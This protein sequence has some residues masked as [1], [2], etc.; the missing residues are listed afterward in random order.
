MFIIG[1]GNVNV[2]ADG[3][4]TEAQFEWLKAVDYRKARDLTSIPL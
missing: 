3:V 2:I 4:E 1:L